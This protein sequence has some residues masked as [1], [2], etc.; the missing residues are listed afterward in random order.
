MSIAAVIVA[1]GVAACPKAEKANANA[2]ADANADA[3][4][5]ASASASADAEEI[6]KNGCL[7]CHS[8]HMLAQQRLTR[9]QWQK[10]VV[11]M[12]GWGANV[13]PA[14]VAPL[15]AH[16]SAKYG[17][18]AGPYEPETI[19]T[20]HAVFE[21]AALPDDPV[22]AGDAL[23]GKPLFLEKCSGCHGADARGGGLGVALVD[24]P[25]LYRAPDVAKTVRVRRGKMLPVPMTDAEVGDVLAYLRTLKNPLP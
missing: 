6:V 2:N 10:V 16:L 23:R 11:K 18:D 21:I 19:T 20:E 1:G 15:I 13:E 22:P 4:A 14:E 17:P 24:R 9:A 5:S 12:V 3:S 8:E 25:V 7:L